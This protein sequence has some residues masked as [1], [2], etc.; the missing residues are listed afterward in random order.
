MSMLKEVKEWID[1]INERYYPETKDELCTLILDM[2]GQCGITSFYIP[3][4]VPEELVQLQKECKKVLSNYDEMP[5]LDSDDIILLLKYYPEKLLPEKFINKI[6]V[7]PVEELLAETY[8]IE[9]LKQA[10]KIKQGVKA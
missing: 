4:P 10:I 6:D 9:Q 2:N 3:K 7:K 5:Y 1:S 8:T